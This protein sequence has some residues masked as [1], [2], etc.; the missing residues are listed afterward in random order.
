LLWVGEL[1]ILHIKVSYN[2]LYDQK[3]QNEFFSNFVIY[4]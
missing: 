3:A 2:V 1:R 4:T